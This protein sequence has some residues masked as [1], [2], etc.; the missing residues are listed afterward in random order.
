M[1]Q[2]QKSQE[3]P[4]RQVIFHKK[5]AVF[6]AA[7]CILLALVAGFLIFVLNRS[8]QVQ[9][10]IKDFEQ[11]VSVKN[12]SDGEVE[13]D[14]PSSDSTDSDET[15]DTP[16]NSSSTI[17][18]SHEGSDIIENKEK[19]AGHSESKSQT[20]QSNNSTSNT[21]QTEQK[22][23]ISSPVQESTTKAHDINNEYR[24]SLQSK[25]GIKIAYGNELPNYRPQNRNVNQ[26]N[27]EVRIR[28]VMRQLEV[29]LS[30]YPD[31]FFKEVSDS[32]LTF[33]FISSV[34]G[35][36]FA[37]L[38]DHEFGDDIKIT[39]AVDYSSYNSYVINHEIMHWIDCIMSIRAYPKNYFSEYSKFNPSEFNYG[40]VQKDLSFWSNQ[41]IFYFVS[42][43]A[44]TN[45]LEDRAE[46]FSQMMSRSYDNGIFAS[47]SVLRQKALVISGQ[48]KQ[49]FKTA[50]G[51]KCH[52][53]QFI[54]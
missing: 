29:E 35:N 41:K 7:D 11:T 12:D 27:D 19:Q 43:Y 26:L 44:Q 1:S 48:I 24:E 25:F 28:T 47:D 34:E 53:D 21:P 30:K 38:I 20:Q 31:G 16:L 36:A 50:S 6:V 54:Q 5:L 32:T 23:E 33:Y 42:D 46:T 2:K 51:K 45:V 10:E 40:T 22:T 8:N 49:Y 15:E 9:T 37:G 3:K 52:W 18:Q 39:Y 14:T 13:T 4:S 17:E